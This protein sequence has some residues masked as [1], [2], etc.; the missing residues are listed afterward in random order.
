[1]LFSRE[2][3]IVCSLRTDLWQSA[4]FGRF[5]FVHA[6]LNTRAKLLVVK[7]QFTAVA[8]TAPALLLLRVHFVGLVEPSTNASLLVA[9]VY[10]YHAR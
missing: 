4:R 7:Q 9:N 8:D 2:R 3:L 5:K 10:Q 1:M 6:Y